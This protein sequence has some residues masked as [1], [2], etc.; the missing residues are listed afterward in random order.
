[1]TEDHCNPNK[2][3]KCLDFY[4]VYNLNVCGFRFGQLHSANVYIQ[5]MIHDIQHINILITTNNVHI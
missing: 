3:V 2:P 4:S 1:M 5:F